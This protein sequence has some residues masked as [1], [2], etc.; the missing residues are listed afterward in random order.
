M[1]RSQQ[2]ATRGTTRKKR[3]QLNW[4]AESFRLTAFRSTQ[5]Q[6]LK[7]IW[8]EITGQQ[9]SQRAEELHLG[10]LAEIGQFDNAKLTVTQ[11]PNRIDFGLSDDASSTDSSKLWFEIGKFW[12]REEPIASRF[13]EWLSNLGPLSRIAYAAT[14]IYPTETPLDARMELGRILRTV[15]F[16]PKQDRE[17]TLSINRPRPSS[18]LSGSKIN[19]ISKWSALQRSSI[20]FDPIAGSAVSAKPENSIVRVE[21][22]I[23]TPAERSEPIPE[24]KVKPLFMELVEFGN[25]ILREGDV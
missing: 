4:L 16:N 18:V 11:S 13:A 12:E 23:N 3:V 25:E 22:D 10:Q 6:E 21:I 20:I 9:P 19:R 17:L 14:V 24:S 15:K 5:D 8:A 2:R 1:A 7:P